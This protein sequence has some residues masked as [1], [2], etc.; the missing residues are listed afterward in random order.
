MRA[1]H[2]ISAGG[3]STS[4]LKT[5]Q[6]QQ[7]RC[8][9]QKRKASPS[10]DTSLAS[11]VAKAPTKGEP[12][13]K[14]MAQQIKDGGGDIGPQEADESVYAARLRASHD[15]RDAVEKIED[16]LM[17]E[18]AGALGRSG[19]KCDLHFLL[20]ERQG[21]LCDELG[22]KAREAHTGQVALQESVAEFNRLRREAEGARR[23]LIIHRQAV[24]FQ[25]A[26]YTFVESKWP[27]PPKREV[28]IHLAEQGE[29]DGKR[30]VTVSSVE[31]DGKKAEADRNELWRERMEYLARR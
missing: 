12:A 6:L 30:M 24:G 23:D 15:H 27:L 11:Y 10:S 17:E 13:W 25:Q 5:L 21:K 20:L 16:E 2:R 1:F 31:V 29:V 19:I 26:N 18:M 22:V 7:R 3:H 28:K 8:F 9:F 14:R 4:T